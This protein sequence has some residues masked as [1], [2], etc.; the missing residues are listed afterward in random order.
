VAGETLATSV[1]YGGVDGN[2]ASAEIEGKRL[3]IAV[4]RR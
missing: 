3:L 4:E 2:A 1:T